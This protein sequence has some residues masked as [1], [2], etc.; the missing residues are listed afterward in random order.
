[1]LDR[2]YQEVIL[3]HY[4]N[5]R[6]RGHLE[7]PKI[8]Q[9]GMNPLCGDEITL[10]LRV[11]D[12]V[13][14][15]IAFDGHGCAISQASASMLVE[16]VKGKSVAEAEEFLQQVLAMFRGD[17]EPDESRFGELA[18]LAGVRFIPQRTKCA[19]LA[20]HTLEEALQH[21]NGQTP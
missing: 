6:G 12:G 1:M 20:W 13:I 4:R 18:Y 17:V 9:E 16:A 5:P 21:T 19:T 8:V 14:E 15:D 10:E 7:A 2:F 3:D 11:R